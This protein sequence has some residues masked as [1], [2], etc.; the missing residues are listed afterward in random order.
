[1][2]G[3]RILTGVIWVPF[4][5]L[6][7]WDAGWGFFGVVFFCGLFGTGE[8]LWMARQAGYRPVYALSLLLALAMLI[9]AAQA[10][11]RA[12]WT[13]G[14]FGG[15]TVDGTFRLALGIIVLASLAVMLPRTEQHG[16]LNDWAVTMALPLYTAGL[17]Q[18][19]IPL[20]FHAQPLA[21]PLTWP[22]L[23]MVASWSCDIAAF[24]AGRAFG[25]VRLAPLISPAKSVEG[26][27]AGL[28][29]A[30]LAGLLFSLGTELGPLRMA[31]FGLTVGLGSVVGDLVESL[32]KRQFGVK[33]SGVIMPGHGG[34]L[35]RMDALLFSAAA[36]YFYLQ[37]VTW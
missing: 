35:D 24:F 29:M 22:L 17:V 21:E 30:S 1:V 27:V 26:A 37:A 13:P 28:V 11:G 23:V 7:A 32:L 33:D 4:L 34:L 6:A 9:D 19:F 10:S 12:P 25:K 36:A 20:R 5:A 2:L 18:F 15:A 8:A 14:L 16:T 3:R 31:G